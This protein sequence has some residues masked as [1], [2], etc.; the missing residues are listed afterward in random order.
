MYSCVELLRRVQAKGVKPKKRWGQNFLVD[1]NIRDFIVDA[2]D[3]DGKNAIEVGPGHG[4]LT[5]R[6]AERAESLVAVEVDKILCSH[7]RELL[8]EKSNFRLVC[9]DVLKT[10][11]AELGPYPSVL[12]SNLPYSISSPFFFKLWDEEPDIPYFVVMLQAEVAGRLT[13]SPGS[14]D[15][16]VLSVLYSLTHEIRHL[17]KV[18]RKCF[19]PQPEV[20][21]VIV[22][23]VKSR[24]IEKGLK[25]MLK[26]L[27]NAAFKYRRKKLYKALSVELPDIDWR[28]IILNAGLDAEKRP[29]AFAPGEWLE[30]A[31]R[32]A[33]LDKSI[34]S[35]G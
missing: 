2:A 25:K 11:F 21:S 28:Q 7:I 10:P 14:K 35:G 15:Y 30:L 33:F 34:N 4:A 22:K 17:K 32:C 8:G 19:W 23:G 9:A 29:D 1:D 26:V 20:D 16:G 24:S 5:V 27:V 3:V 31:K 12:V 6:L 13:A 18:P